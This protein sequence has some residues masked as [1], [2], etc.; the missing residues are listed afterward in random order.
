MNEKEIIER[1]LFSDT[2]RYADIMDRP[3][4][5]S[6]GH[7]PMM[8][9]DRAGQFSPFAALTGFNNLIQKKAA[10]YTHKKYLSASQERLIHQRLHALAGIRQI[11]TI[12]YFND[13]VG[14]YEEFKDEIT[15]VKEERGRVFFKEHLSLPI[16]N[17]KEIRG[18]VYCIIKL[19][20]SSENGGRKFE[21][22][23]G[24]VRALFR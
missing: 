6:K 12:N 7:L 4:Q 14:Y 2:S 3:Y 9:E 19:T 5:P 17:V 22:N 23:L 8:R 20:I 18:W 1:Q 15:V 21:G 11:V 13:E 16:A 24:E 10:I